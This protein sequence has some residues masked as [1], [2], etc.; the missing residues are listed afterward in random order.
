MRLQEAVL[1]TTALAALVAALAGCS[2]SDHG[3]AGPPVGQGKGAGMPVPVATALVAEKTVPLELSAIGTARALASVSVKARVDGPLA[4]VLAKQGDELKKGD[5]IFEIDPRPFQS[6]LR[7]A[8]AV[9]ARDQAS[10]ENAEADMKRTDELA[11]TKAVPATVVDANRAKVAALKASVEADKAAAGTAQLQLSFCSITSAVDGR[12]GLL[13]VDEG[14]MVKNNDTILAVVNQTKPIFVDFAV[15]ERVL[16]DVRDAAARGHLRVEAAT[17]QRPDDRAVGA[18]E[19]INNQVDTTTG[20]LLLRARFENADERLWPGQFLNVTLTLG[21]LTNATVVPSPAVQ[22]GQNGEFVFVVK[23]DATVEKRPVTLGPVRGAETVIQSGVKPG[24]KVVTDGQLRLVPGSKVNEHTAGE[25]PAG[26]PKQ[27][28]SQPVRSADFQVCRVV[29]L[30]IR[31]ASSFRET[32]RL[33]SQR[34]ARSLPLARPSGPCLRFAQAIPFA[35]SQAT[36]V[37]GFGNLR[38]AASIAGVLSS[39]CPE[40]R[41]A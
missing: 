9:L 32:C 20:T 22:T 16:Q 28:A 29:D 3:P 34:L 11:G 21:Q 27:T 2:K 17:P 23:P 41:P 7:Q 39:P 15:P 24:E 33:G 12:M 19:V 31:N 4:R 13:L 38:S 14:N 40:R 5:P 36:Q 6:A 37:S 10:L 18:L 8:E 25:A 26:K 1:K 35:A 30:Q